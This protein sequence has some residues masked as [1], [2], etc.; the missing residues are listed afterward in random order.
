MCNQ[1][2]IDVLE[3][4]RE[5]DY[6][7]GSETQKVVQQLVESSCLFRSIVCISD[8]RAKPA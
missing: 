2:C 5:D 1:K 7:G 3:R 8:G 6:D 4:I